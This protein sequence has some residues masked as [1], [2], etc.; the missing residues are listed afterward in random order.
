MMTTFRID[1]ARLNRAS[2]EKK[3]RFE[4]IVRNADYAVDVRGDRLY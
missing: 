2:P 3:D 4:R 1:F